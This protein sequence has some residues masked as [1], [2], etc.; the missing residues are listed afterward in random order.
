MKAQSRASP[1]DRP[2]VEPEP[3][4]QL[5]EG[6]AWRG[7]GEAEANARFGNNPARTRTCQTYLHEAQTYATIPPQYRNSKTKSI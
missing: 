6:E 4:L 7:L 1:L 5:G 3:R 2:H